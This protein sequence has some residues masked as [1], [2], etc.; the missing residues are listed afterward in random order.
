MLHDHPLWA[1]IFY[2]FRCGD[3][4]SALKLLLQVIFVCFCFVCSLIFPFCSPSV[5]QTA[6]LPIAYAHALLLREKI[7]PSMFGECAAYLFSR[8]SITARSLCSLKDDMWRRLSEEYNR[9]LATNRHADPFKC[10]MFMLRQFPVLPR[11]LFPCVTSFFL[12]SWSL[13]AKSSHQPL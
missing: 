13:Q 10:A 11:C 4:E 7:D 6:H 2:L 3:A 9:D 1:Q 8:I 12:C 5:M